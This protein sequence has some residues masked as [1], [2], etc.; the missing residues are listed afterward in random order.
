MR[1]SPAFQITIRCYGVWQSAVA[2]LGLA[3]L[4]TVVAWLWQL[5]EARTRLDWLF[6]AV[7]IGVVGAAFGCMRQ[8]P[9]SLRWDTRE[10]WLGSAASVGDE[11]SSGHVDAPVDLSAWM[12]LRFVRASPRRRDRVTWI[13]VQRR[14]LEAHWH[15]LRCAVY[16]ARAA[17][18]A[19]PSAS[20]VRP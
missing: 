19:H 11:P 6:G 17:A 1:D 7:A 2:V 3:S 9:V 4:A 18:Q 15:A 16:T 12:L 8:R 20:E 10:W 5:G 14:G 13:P